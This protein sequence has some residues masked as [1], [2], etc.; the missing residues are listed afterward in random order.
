M[1]PKSVIQTTVRPIAEFFNTFVEKKSALRE[2]TEWSMSALVSVT[3]EHRLAVLAE[4]AH[5]FGTVLGGLDDRE[6]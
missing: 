5:R 2:P 4:G 3:L 1:A 6:M